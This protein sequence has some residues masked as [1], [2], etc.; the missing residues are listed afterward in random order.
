MTP[1]SSTARRTPM[2]LSLSDD[3]MRPHHGSSPPSRPRLDLQLPVI[4][5]CRIRASC[6]RSRPAICRDQE[7]NFEKNCS[8]CKWRR[9]STSSTSCR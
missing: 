6:P 7:S 3:L 8:R 2:L 9:R 5:C 1:E 4:C